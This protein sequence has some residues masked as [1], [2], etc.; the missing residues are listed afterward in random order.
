M[1][2]TSDPKTAQAGASRSPVRASGSREQDKQK[3]IA[4]F[5]GHAAAD[6]YDVFA[7]E[8]SALLIR[9]AVELGRF[10]S[11][12][13]VADLGCGSGVFSNLLRQHG[14]VPVGLD[15]SPKLIELGQRKYPGIEF[16]EGDVER[17]PFPDGSFDG[18]L[19]A[20]IV[21]H[22]PDPSQCAAEV[23]RVLRP[24]GRFVA[25]DPN[26]MNPF[27]WLYRDHAS[28]FYSP[29]GVTENE[30][31]MLARQAAATFRAAGFTVET[32][33][34]SNLRYRYVA[35]GRVRRLLPLYNAIDSMLFTPG[36]M[37]PFRSFVLTFGAKP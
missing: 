12:D 13:Q 33:Y 29:I 14:C 6:S 36:F 7:P 15:I 2:V 18:V 27:M 8:S 1:N 25:F 30:R 34:L 26:R 20:G 11:G 22:F 23:F 4:F 3:E 5:D 28:P 9:T 32:D 17:L 24:G 31:P 19:L 35:S 21:H 16:L 37:R 10:K